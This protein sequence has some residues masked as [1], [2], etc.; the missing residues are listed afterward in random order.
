MQLI[1]FIGLQASGKS[2]FYQTALAPSGNYV[3]VSKDRLRNNAHPGQRQAQLIEEALGAGRSVVVDN[4][5]PTKADRAELIALGRRFGAEVI[6]YCFE[7]SV[8]GSLE[9]NRQRTGRARVPDKAVYITAHRLTWPS[10]DEGF[11]VIYRV[12]IA[13]EMSFKVERSDK[14]VEEAEQDERP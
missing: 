2:T 4:T 10:Y 5:N 6:G 11:D 9:R 12:Q 14:N 8:G 3:Y 1:I 13:G 7:S